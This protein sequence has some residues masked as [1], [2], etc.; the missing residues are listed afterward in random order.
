MYSLINGEP[1]DENL[2]KKYFMAQKSVPATLHTGFRL[3]DDGDEVKYDVG[4]DAG[5]VEYEMWDFGIL[6]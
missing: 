5:T 2:N 1:E 4:A 3:F 6:Q